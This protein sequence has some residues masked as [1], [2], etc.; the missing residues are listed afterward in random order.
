MKL[1]T[2]N[3]RGVVGTGIPEVDNRRQFLRQLGLTRQQAR[4]LVKRSFNVPNFNLRDFQRRRYRMSVELGDKRQNEVDAIVKNEI[5]EFIAANERRVRPRTPSPP[6]NINWNDQPNSPPRRSRSASIDDRFRGRS[7]ERNEDRFEQR[8][9]PGSD[10]HDGD[11]WQ[12]QQYQMREH[13]EQQLMRQREEQLI[14]E[15]EEHIMRQ[16]EEQHFDH[17]NNRNTDFQFDNR[18]MHED[19]ENPNSRR[20]PEQFEFDGDDRRHVN[21]SPRER[22]NFTDENDD[23][24]MANR[25]RQ[26]NDDRY[27]PNQMLGNRG[28]DNRNDNYDDRFERDFDNPDFNPHS[29]ERDNNLCLRGDFERNLAEDRN[30]GFRNVQ[31]ESEFRGPQLSPPPRNLER[32]P[33]ASFNNK[34]PRYQRI[35]QVDNDEDRVFLI[36]DSD[37]ESDRDVGEQRGRSNERGNFIDDR[38]P[39]SY[40]DTR[41]NNQ[42]QQRYSHSDEEFRRS[43]DFRQNFD[44]QRSNFSIPNNP[45]EQHR[46]GRNFINHSN[47]PDEIQNRQLH[48]R[49][50]N[51]FQRDQIMP[52]F[53]PRP[54]SNQMMNMQGPEGGGGGRRMPL[55][56]NRIQQR[57]EQRDQRMP[58]PL[59]TNRYQT[60]RNVA[61]FQSGQNQSNLNNRIGSG[62]QFDRMNRPNPVTATITSQQAIGSSLPPAIARIINKSRMMGD[63]RSAMIQAQA[64]NLPLAA[65]QSQAR[66]T[67]T[68][69]RQNQVGNRSNAGPPMA[70]QA[71]N[72]RSSGAQGQARKTITKNNQN[73]VGNKVNI[74]PPIARNPGQ[75]SVNND[76]APRTGQKRAGDP[77]ARSRQTTNVE[78]KQRKIAGKQDFR[79]AGFKF[80]YIRNSVNRLPQPES[81]S[82]A[83]TFFEQKPDY[84]TNYLTDSVGDDESVNV[85]TNDDDDDDEVEDDDDDDDDNGGN[86]NVANKNT[87]YVGVRKRR[88]NKKKFQKRLQRDWTELYRN[89]NYKDW[90]PWWTD[91]KWCGVEIEKQL[92]TF[93]NKS[94]KYRFIPSYPNATTEQVVNN[95]LKCAHMAL[96]KNLFNHYRNMR[97][98]FLL[99][100]EIFLE[101]LSMENVEQLQ[102][103]IR[104]IPNHLWLFKMRSMV[105]LWHKQYTIIEK[106]NPDAS[107][108]VGR[109]WKNPVFHWLAK[110]AFDELKSISEKTWPRHKDLFNTLKSK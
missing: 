88:A 110:Q 65:D 67:I 74:A 52:N 17:S 13:E 27:N 30:Q 40:E 32:A 76:N 35:V 21:Y 66:R 108:V 62:Q 41:F 106:G 60:N 68:N 93:K 24:V 36:R 46:Q 39:D 34:G 56:G 16:R 43:G 97:T 89:K 12:Q 86:K 29:R 92:G 26:M 57:V 73:Q 58:M 8:R 37:S 94:I 78:A 104:N 33:A 69:R 1:R 42:N 82:Y 25:S 18:R 59:N 109:Q 45:M 87:K 15:R 28:P 70:Q 19:N 75:K 10:Q 31:Y 11:R 7:R 71:R 102:E 98:I 96:E 23:L 79:I 9:S 81:E 61:D 63:G 4:S 103:M 95:V 90:L 101:N 84:Y 44:D 83:L 3:R 22:F 50:G 80:P 85:D 107:D 48:H 72:P 64:N 14:R 99:M 105:Y 20:Q 49:D 6:R 51:D 53:L 5:Y 38:P 91:Y 2:G 100:N 55:D 77:P 47:I 54:G